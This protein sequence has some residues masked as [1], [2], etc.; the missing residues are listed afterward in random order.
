M[1]PRPLKSL[2]TSKLLYEATRRLAKGRK[3]IGE[4]WLLLGLKPGG[5]A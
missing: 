5:D 1:K 3:A 4:A 2:P